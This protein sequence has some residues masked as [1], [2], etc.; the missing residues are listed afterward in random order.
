VCGH[1]GIIGPGICD[2]DLDVL[3][4]LAQ[5]IVV[6]GHDGCGILQ[7][8]HHSKYYTV[9]KSNEEISTFLWYHKHAKG[10]DRMLLNTTSDTFFCV[11]V[12]AATRGSL[13]TKNAH[14]FDFPNLVGMHNGT[15]KETDYKPIG[16]QTDSEMMFADM[17][18]KG[19]IPVLSA[20]DKDSAYA[21]VV[22]DK[23]TKEIY[24]G[25]NQHRPLFCTWNS[26]RRVFYYASEYGL[27]EWILN[28]NGIKRD[29]IYSFSTDVIHRFSPSDVNSGRKPSWKVYNLAE[30][31]KKEEKKPAYSSITITQQQGQISKPNLRIVENKPSPLPSVQ[32]A[33]EK[34]EK[35]QEKTGE[36]SRAVFPRSRLRCTCIGCYKDMDL[37]EQYQGNE[38]RPGEYLCKECDDQW[39]DVERVKNFAIN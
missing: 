38:I 8:N 21:V 14:P 18:D 5:C 4:Q 32:K 9:E 27:L 30:E 22:Y 19:V 35:G 12:R 25:R 23:R 16:D 28:R 31:K 36:K 34:D 29:K 11:H 10:G 13:T 15:L 20:L 24:I 3:E 1:V 37:L 7:G 6:R 17:N 2:T 26:N 39:S 33:K